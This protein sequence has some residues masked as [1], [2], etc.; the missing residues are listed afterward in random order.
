MDNLWAK[1]II[2]ST[3]TMEMMCDLGLQGR[4][5]SIY[6]CFI[7]GYTISRNNIGPG[8]INLFQ[9][10]YWLHLPFISFTYE[11]PCIGMAL[12]GAK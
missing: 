5:A 1:L 7:Q 12:S 9:V 4:Q 8:D 6:V 11:G 10:L 2:Q 3:K